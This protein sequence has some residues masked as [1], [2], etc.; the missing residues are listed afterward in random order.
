M[1]LDPNGARVDESGVGGY[2]IL[3]DHSAHVF[4]RKCP[5]EVP[6]VLQ[7][8]SS[9]GVLVQ[10]MIAHRPITPIC[11]NCSKSDQLPLALCRFRVR[12]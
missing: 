4:L 12:V 10:I 7:C 2:I 5:A 8:K 1:C 9:R 3:K 6:I 11:H